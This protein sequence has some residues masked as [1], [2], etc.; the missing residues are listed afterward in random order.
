MRGEK[1]YLKVRDFITGHRLFEGADRIITGFSGGADSVCLLFILKELKCDGTL[2]E[3]HLTAMHVHHGIRGDEADRDAAFT[4]AFCEKH[5]LEYIEERA[6]IPAIAKESGESEEMTGRRIRYEMFNKEAGPGTMIATAHHKNDSA[7]TVLMNIAR[8]TGL[9]GLS[10]I[11]ARSGNVVRPLMCLTRAQIEHFVK[12]ND[13]GFVSDSTNNENIY[14]RNFIR[15]EIIPR[16]E[17][18]VNSAF[19]DHIGEM[20]AIAERADEYFKVK[21][22]VLFRECEES[23]GKIFMP[24][25]LLEK[26]GG[27][28]DRI[29]RE[30]M[31]GLCFTKLAGDGRDLGSERIRA[32]DGLKSTG[33]LLELPRG[34][35]AVKRADGVM[36]YSQDETGGDLFEQS[37]PKHTLEDVG[38]DEDPEMLIFRDDICKKI[39]TGEKAEIF[40]QGVRICM[41]MV[42]K[43]KKTPNSD[44]TKYFDYDKIKGSVCLRKRRAGDFITVTKE[45]KKRKLKSELIDRKIPSDYRDSIPVIARGSECLWAV[46]VREG[47]S[48]R[49]DDSS[50]RILCMEISGGNN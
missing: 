32:L 50:L 34:I 31:Y 12:V 28:E 27:D 3:L 47:I 19:I 16:F 41:Y 45:G 2:P 11:R 49:A 14:T 48:A 4:K 1:I 30:Y 43:H 29:L 26:I 24:D 10:G 18:R 42:K 7:E 36:L 13:L 15:N 37:V 46:G 39:E 6:D 17:N 9:A 40:G 20:S 5:G 44:Y 8:G 22:E 21:A 23:R 38:A 35:R 33:K 25:G